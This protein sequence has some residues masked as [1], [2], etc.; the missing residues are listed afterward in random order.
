MKIKKMDKRFRLFNSG[1][2]AY[3]VDMPF[4]DF[5]Q[6]DSTTSINARL[7]EAYGPS[8]RVPHFWGSKPARGDWFHD[9][10]PNNHIRLYFR[11]EEQAIYLTM[12]Q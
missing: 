6:Y 4:K 12:I 2:A 10:K 7:T 1:H 9:Y 5:S 3:V 8:Q 11:R